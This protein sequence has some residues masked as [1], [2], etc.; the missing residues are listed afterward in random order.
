MTLMSR[1]AVVLPR[2]NNVMQR[3]ET[4]L[5]IKSLTR[6]VVCNRLHEIGIASN[7]VVVRHGEMNPRDVLITRQT[8]KVHRW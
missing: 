2:N 8:Q 7:R 4:E 3:R 5:I 1:A 6:I